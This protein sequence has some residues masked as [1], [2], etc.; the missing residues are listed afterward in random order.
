MREQQLP[1]MSIKTTELTKRFTP[2][3]RHIHWITSRFKSSKEVVAVDHVNLEIK[4][5]ELF[6][7][8]GP[9]GAGKTTLIKVLCT[10]LLPDHGTAYVNGFDIVSEQMNVRKSIGTLFSV[11]ERG[12]YWRLTVYRNLE[13]FAALYNIPRTEKRRKIIEILRLLDLENVMHQPFQKLSGGM[14]RKLALARAL[15]PNPPIL[16]LDEPLLQLDAH[17]SK[18]IRDFIRNELCKKQG[19]TILYTTHQIEEA[20]RICDRV[21]IMHHGKILVCETPET[22]RHM[23][24]KRNVVALRVNKISQRQVQELRKMNCVQSAEQEWDREINQYKVVVQ[25]DRMDSLF[26]VLEYLFN[27]DVKLLD[28]N[29]IE[30]TLEEAFLRLTTKG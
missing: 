6:G 8:L 16:L 24:K 30:T 29:N 12:F 4:K 9:N 25:L 10:L 23:I 3:R 28:L 27:K 15:L 13:F 1:E 26:K 2:Q 19:K 14:K 22:I 21:A 20:G 11:G 7:L 5:G 17:S 18:S